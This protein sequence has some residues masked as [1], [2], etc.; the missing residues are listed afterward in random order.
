MAILNN[1]LS[2]YLEV[3]RRMLQNLAP[4]DEMGPFYSSVR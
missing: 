3:V 2:L 1:V 4:L